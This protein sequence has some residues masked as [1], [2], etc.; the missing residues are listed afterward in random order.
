LDELLLLLELFHISLLFLHHLLFKFA[1][2]VFNIF[3][4]K[5]GSL[6]ANA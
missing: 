3:L 6:A 1:L 4:K 5:L 2:H